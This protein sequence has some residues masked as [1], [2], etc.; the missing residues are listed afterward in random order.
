[1]KAKL[2]PF[3][4]QLSARDRQ[5]VVAVFDLCMY[6]CS[7]DAVLFQ[8]WD[9]EL[10]RKLR[11]TSIL[12]ESYSGEY[13]CLPPWEFV[14]HVAKEVGASELRSLVFAQPKIWVAVQYG[15]GYV[16]R[17]PRWYGNAFFPTRVVSIQGQWE[18]HKIVV[19]NVLTNAASAVVIA[20]C[21]QR[22]EVGLELQKFASLVC[23]KLHIFHTQS[24]PQGNP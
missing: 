8:G 13:S 1:M 16:R 4:D 10:L 2:Q 12:R 5:R 23:E 24:L 15:K 3:L 11:L 20:Q 17:N 22:G 6:Q 19:A 7:P 18:Q 9:C 21:V 14:D